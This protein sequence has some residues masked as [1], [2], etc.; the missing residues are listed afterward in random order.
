MLLGQGSGSA[1]A[2]PIVVPLEA[3]GVRAVAA[4]EIH[5]DAR[6]DD[7]VT[8]LVDA[9]ADVDARDRQGSKPLMFAAQNGNLRFVKRLL[10]ADADASARWIGD[11]LTALDFAAMNERER[12]A[13]ILRNV[14]SAG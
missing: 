6:R 11:G 10:V 7:G 2:P 8:A 4:R 3:A 13:A 5:P 9:G 12:A 14:S 1:D